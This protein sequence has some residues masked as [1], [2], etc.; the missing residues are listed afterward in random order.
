MNCADEPGTTRH[1]APS[2]SLSRACE[3]PCSTSWDYL[4]SLSV[5]TL[6]RLTTTPNDSP[7]HTLV[8]PVRRASNNPCH[9]AAQRTSG[10]ADHA[11]TSTGQSRPSHTAPRSSA[12]SA[13]H[14]QAD[15]HAR[16]DY[17]RWHH[18][19]RRHS[20]CRYGE[21]PTDVIAVR[22]F[23]PCPMEP[24]PSSSPST[25]RSHASV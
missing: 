9:S 4:H 10:Y 1:T 22:E 18:Q 17:G 20:H 21:M 13:L 11:T 2:P 3:V 12:C 8:R 23:T 5:L 6:P 15:D 24:T 25:T 7:L 14:R 19:H 16:P